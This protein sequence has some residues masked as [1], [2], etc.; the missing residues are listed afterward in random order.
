MLKKHKTVKR[1]KLE[2]ALSR[3]DKRVEAKAR[4]KIMKEL[5]A[6]LAESSWKE[7]PLR[8]NNGNKLKLK[9]KLKNNRVIVFG[10]S[11]PSPGTIYA[12]VAKMENAR[13]MQSTHI[14]GLSTRYQA[15][16]IFP[17]LNIKVHPFKSSSGY[18]LPKMWVR[19]PPS[20]PTREVSGL[21]RVQFS[22]SRPYAK[23]VQRQDVGIK[24]RV[25]N[26]RWIDCTRQLFGAPFCK[27]EAKPEAFKCGYILEASFY[28]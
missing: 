23:V 24:L 4:Q 18:T 5:E 12:R 13:Y 2:Q 20:A 27:D 22:N 16:A 11:N 15:Q 21:F 8:G 3:R 17:K 25:S 28:R 26:C 1:V 6:F 14:S 9:L 7:F 10:G 19:F